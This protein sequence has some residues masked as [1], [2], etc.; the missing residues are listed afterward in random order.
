MFCSACGRVAPSGTGVWSSTLSLIA[1]PTPGRAPAAAA[2]RA[3]RPRRRSGGRARRT[4]RRGC[5]SAPRAPR[6]RGRRRRT[7]RPRARRAPA[8][9]SRPT[10]VASRTR[11]VLVAERLAL[12]EVRAHE[13]LLHRVLAAVRGRQVDQAVGVEAVAAA[14]AVE[15]VLEPL[16]RRQLGHLRVGLL[17]LLD[18]HAVLGREVLGRGVRALGR[19]ARV[20]LEAAPGQLDLVTVRELLER[21]LE[22]T[23]ADVAPRAH[24]VG[25][26]LDG[27]RRHAAPC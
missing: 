15:V 4:A 16:A 26:D 3:A 22:A 19:R 8:A 12:G 2:R 23:L 5:R 13:A 11:I 14:R 7:P 20:E 18:A 9:A 25:P 6:R 24:D 27:H 10:S 17:G 21:V 1:P